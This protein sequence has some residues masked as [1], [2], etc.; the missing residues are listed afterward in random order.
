VPKPNISPLGALAH[1]PAH[2]RADRLGKRGGSNRAP[3]RQQAYKTKTSHPQTL[4]LN[5]SCLLAIRAAAAAAHLVV[6]WL[7]AAG[8]A[9]QEASRSAG[10][11]VSGRYITQR[12]KA[13]KSSIS[14]ACSFFIFYIH[15]LA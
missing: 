10:D 8:A 13:L 9:G 6:G 3:F 2:P 7:R 1:P 15:L 5:P 14:F 11:R 12:S 4:L